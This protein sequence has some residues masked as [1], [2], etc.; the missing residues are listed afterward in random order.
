MASR[1]VAA[2]ALLVA[3]GMFLYWAERAGYLPRSTKS[4]PPGL[5]SALL[6]PVGTLD[7]ETGNAGTPQADL[8]W[9]MAAREQPYLAAHGEALI[10]ESGGMR[11]EDMD[12]AALARLRYAP[13]RYSAWGPDAPVRKDAAFAV[14]THEGNFARIRIAEIRDNYDLRLEWTLVAV[15][16]APAPPAPDPELA[17]PALHD[18][19][20]AAYRAQRYGE[21]LKVCRD[22]AAPG[23]REAL[24]KE[25]CLRMLAVLH[26]DSGR[27]HQ[28][29]QHFALAVDLVRAMPPPETAEHRVAL[30]ADL[31]DL[32]EALVQLGLRGT[33]RRAL[34]EARELYLATEP[35]HPALD[36]IDAQLRRLDAPGK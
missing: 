11:W 32:G 15:P 35:G 8:H 12:A 19:A 16:A 23:P 34:L 6:P 7:L 13:D 14:R 33:A 3:A 31:Q 9:G 18:E 10:A 1:W 28:A 20:L 26:R 21:A 4:R 29:A 36:S 17:W 22:W 30:R 27:L 2:I 24:L 25:R 5:Q